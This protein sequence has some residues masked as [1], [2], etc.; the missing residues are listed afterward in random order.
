MQRDIVMNEREAYFAGLNCTQSGNLPAEEQWVFIRGLFDKFGCI[1]ID[2]CSMA[3]EEVLANEIINFSRIP[4]TYKNQRLAWQ[5]SN[6]I[7]FLS[8]LYDD[9]DSM[10]YL[11]K[12]KVQ[13]NQM[14]GANRNFKWCKTH[15]GAVKPYKKRASDSGWD[16][17]LIREVKKVGMM[18]LY[19]TGLSVSPIFGYYFD[20]VPRS[21]IINLGYIMANSVGV[22]DRTYTG[23]IMA[24]LVKIDDS[25]PDLVLPARIV[26]II[27][28]PIIH[29]DFDKVATLDVTDR[30][31]GGFGSTG[32]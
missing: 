3:L 27:P 19:G 5:N 13:Y 15:E 26:Q 22:I 6:A 29:A 10:Y 18:T 14:C 25:Q 30:A 21:N 1:G 8:K 20:L 2:E 17:T 11:V 31:D 16:L 32:K 7:D 24:A 28:R 9:A 23:E 12:H 4:C